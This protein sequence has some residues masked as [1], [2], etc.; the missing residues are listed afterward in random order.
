MKAKKQKPHD[1]TTDKKSQRLKALGNAT[2]VVS[3]NCNS[4][5]CNYCKRSF[6]KEANCFANPSFQK[7][8]PT[9]VNKTRGK[10]NTMKPKSPP[11]VSDEQPPIKGKVLWMK[12]KEVSTSTSTYIPTAQVRLLLN[13]YNGSS[14]YIK[15]QLLKAAG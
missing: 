8:D 10:C 3:E 1:E 12:S 6:H 11:K 5:Y 2:N 7:Y 4:N 14:R 13:S 15:C 9:K